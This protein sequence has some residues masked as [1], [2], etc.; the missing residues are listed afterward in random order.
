[1]QL[2]PSVEASTYQPIQLP[3][4]I[5]SIKLAQWARDHRPRKQFGDRPGD[6]GD[7]GI[8]P[9]EEEEQEVDFERG[10]VQAFMELLDNEIRDALVS[11]CLEFLSTALTC[12]SSVYFSFIPP[13]YTPQISIISL[14]HFT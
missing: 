11:Q 9:D 8:G 2:P 6:T 1:M 7:A 13:T 3:T 14:H 12:S 10:D 4:P 5:P